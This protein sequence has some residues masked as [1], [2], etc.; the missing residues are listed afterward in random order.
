[1]IGSSATSYTDNTAN[2]EGYYF[3]RLYAYYAAT[4]CT[5]APASVKYNPNKFY[6]Q[7]YYS[8]TD[9]EETENTALRLYPNPVNQSLKI[10]TEGM[11]QVSVYNMLGQTVYK[12]DWDGNVLNVNTSDWT[13]GLY[14]VKVQTAQ[15]T[16]SRRVSVI[17]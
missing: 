15:G 5:S 2:V 4:D 12:K 17:H 3:Y 11:T 13:E 10:E 16:I 7:V 14:L 8:P 9:V 6:L 1:M